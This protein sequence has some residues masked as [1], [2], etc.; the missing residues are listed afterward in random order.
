MIQNDG[1]PASEMFQTSNINPWGKKKYSPSL[2]G[3]LCKLNSQPWKP[4]GDAKH[5]DLTRSKQW[6]PI[7]IKIVVWS[8]FSVNIVTLWVFEVTLGPFSAFWVDAAATRG[9]ACGSFQR[10]VGNYLGRKSVCFRK[11]PKGKWNGRKEQIL[12]GEFWKSSWQGHWR[13]VGG[14][15]PCGCWSFRDTESQWVTFAGTEG[16]QCLSL[17]FLHAA[18]PQ[19]VCLVL[20]E[21]SLRGKMG[22]E[23][24]CEGREWIK[25]SLCEKG[26]WQQEQL[27]LSW[28][29][30]GEW[31]SA[32]LWMIK[33]P[34]L[35]CSWMKYFSLW[36]KEA[37]RRCFNGCF[38][39]ENKIFP[40]LLPTPRK[41]SLSCA[42]IYCMRMYW[43][44]S[45]V[46]IFRPLEITFIFFPLLN[47]AQV[48]CTFPRIKFA[49]DYF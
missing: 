44:L 6:A 12:Q 31:H 33:P 43:S 27:E 38:W 8:Y 7:Y 28:P 39:S 17:T 49:G 40:E 25:S 46:C 10:F 22:V 35:S 9:A 32:K 16:P 5:F 41:T 47:I 42:G 24:V 30:T 21:K 3:A 34:T 15:G 1:L 14:L 48:C 2:P 36:W 4:G 26:P 29:W 23:L 37:Q 19:L 45:R 20:S 11:N 13:R 18:L